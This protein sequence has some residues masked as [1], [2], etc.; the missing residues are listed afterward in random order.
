MDYRN[1]YTSAHVNV[2]TKTSSKSR[3]SI[4]KKSKNLSELAASTII[5][6]RLPERFQ[7]YKKMYKSRKCAQAKLKNGIQ[8]LSLKP[9]KAKVTEIASPTQNSR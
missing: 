3:V 5:K 8:N 2:K 4:D 1:F 6:P 9:K 7:H